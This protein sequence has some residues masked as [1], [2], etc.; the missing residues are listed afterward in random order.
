[1]WRV[2]SFR[3][4]FLHARSFSLGVEYLIPDTSYIQGVR[5]LFWVVFRPVFGFGLCFPV[6]YLLV[7]AYR[8]YYKYVSERFITCF[9]ENQ[10]HEGRHI[11]GT[12]F[13]HFRSIFLLAFSVLMTT[14]TPDQCSFEPRM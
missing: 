13:M 2:P 1:M 9:R 6:F 4:F 7:R 12:R 11:I 5:L 8:Q 10:H 14:T 3:V